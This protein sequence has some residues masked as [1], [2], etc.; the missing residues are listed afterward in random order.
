MEKCYEFAGVEVV[1]HCPDSLIYTDERRLAPFAVPACSPQAY[2]FAFELADELPL[3]TG[4]L[5][6]AD[7]ALRVYAA[8]A[9]DAADRYVGSVQQGPEHG[10]LLVQRRG[11][12]FRVLLRRSSFPGRIGTNTVLTALQAEHL[13]LPAGG[14]VLHASYIEWQGRAVLFTA[15]SGTGTS[16]QAELWERYRGAKLVN[17]DR[18]VLRRSAASP[19]GFV[20]C[21]LPF[22]GSSRTCLDRELPLAAVVYLGQAPQTTIQRLQ[23]AQAFRR[24]W[25]GC[26]VNVWD[27][28]DLAAAAQIVTEAARAVPVWRLDCTPDE[29]AVAALQNA[30]EREG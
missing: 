24:I 8:D 20:A 29:T 14:V 27:S 2:H 1:I 26:S 30:L 22:S 5:L 9:P 21:G 10:Y 15:P 3:P 19:T 16:T 18:A 23:G 25:E 4:A 11:R 17:G 28:H 6:Y 7:P 12:Q 13:V